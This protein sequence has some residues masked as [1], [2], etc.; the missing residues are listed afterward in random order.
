MEYIHDHKSPKVKVY[1]GATLLKR[2]K[3]NGSEDV[4]ALYLE[5]GLR[6]LASFITR[7]ELPL[8]KLLDQTQIDDAQ[9]KGVLEE[10]VY[11]QLKLLM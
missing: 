6:A 7:E 8:K 9:N 5:I 3:T 4:E 1:E 10:S 2:A 11:F